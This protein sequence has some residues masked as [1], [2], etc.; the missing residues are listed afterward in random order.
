MFQMNPA[1]PIHAT[2]THIIIKAKLATF[3]ATLIPIALMANPKEALDKALL[4]FWSL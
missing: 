3:K 2:I 1:K 4:V